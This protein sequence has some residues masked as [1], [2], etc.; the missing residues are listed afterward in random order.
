M[1]PH[2]NVILIFNRTVLK[3]N[4]ILLS[5]SILPFLCSVIDF[6]IQM[7]SPFSLTFQGKTPTKVIGD[8]QYY[9][10]SI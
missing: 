8:G 7:G 1:A 5:S 9:K 10:H 3:E 4:N 6:K 2:F